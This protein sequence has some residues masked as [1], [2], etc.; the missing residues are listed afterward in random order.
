MSCIHACIADN[1]LGTVVL[2]GK[3]LGCISTQQGTLTSA[4]YEQ[5]LQLLVRALQHG[6]QLQ[7][8]ALSD[9]ESQVCQKLL[10]CAQSDRRVV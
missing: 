2:Q 1:R 6:F 8:Q 3:A 4:Q 7:D 9:V 10:H 5:R